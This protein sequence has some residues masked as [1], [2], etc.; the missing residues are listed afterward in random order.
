MMKKKLFY[1]LAGVCMIAMASCSSKDN[2]QDAASGRGDENTEYS[3]LDDQ[4]EKE[5][6]KYRE[7]QPDDE[8]TEEDFDLSAADMAQ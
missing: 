3:A 1:A 8:M 7:S 5:Y 6:E 4:A 2:E